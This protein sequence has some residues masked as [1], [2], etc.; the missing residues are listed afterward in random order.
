MSH[1]SKVCVCWAR[2]SI[3]LYLRK[4]TY[5]DPLPDFEYLDKNMPAD[6]KIHILEK[7]KEQSTMTFRKV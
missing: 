4:R 3:R 2:R 6:K 7:I 5:G 1:S